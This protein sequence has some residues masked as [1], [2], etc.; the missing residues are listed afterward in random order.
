MPEKDKIE[1][2]RMTDFLIYLALCNQQCDSWLSNN[3][4]QKVDLF[5][6]HGYD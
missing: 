2:T 4:W 6:E 5:K 3:L 1:Y